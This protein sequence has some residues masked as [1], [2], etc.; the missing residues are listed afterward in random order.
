VTGQIKLKRGHINWW[1]ILDQDN[2]GFS[3][4]LGVRPGISLE[5]QVLCFYASVGYYWGWKRGT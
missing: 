1:L 3:L 2:W 4:L 5:V